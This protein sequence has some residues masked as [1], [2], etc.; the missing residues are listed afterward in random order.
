V[1]GG[2]SGDKS[3]LRLLELEQQ[4]MGGTEFSVATKDRH[5]KHGLCEATLIATG[6]KD[7]WSTLHAIPESQT[8]IGLAFLPQN[9]REL[10]FW[11]PS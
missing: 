6:P 9:S 8:L 1:R 7:T 2:G 11:R 3:S 5:E 4:L 10:L